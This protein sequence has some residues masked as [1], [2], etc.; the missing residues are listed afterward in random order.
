MDERKGIITFRDDEGLERGKVIK[1]DL[2]QAIEESLYAI[3]VLSPNYASSTWCLD[4][5][6]KILH[7]KK[8]LGL[9]VFP[10]FYGIDPSDIRHR[11][12]MFG[13][14]FKELQEKFIQ[15]TMK[16]QEWKDA[17]EEIVNLS[18]WHSKNR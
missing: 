11:K 2:F 4:E 10:I 5:L 13:K 8:V 9:Q 3:V 7:S 6:L 1:S 14:A 15:D 17:L 16:V 12:G 18:G